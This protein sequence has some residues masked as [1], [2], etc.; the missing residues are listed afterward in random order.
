MQWPLWGWRSKALVKAWWSR[1]IW[2]ETLFLREPVKDEAELEL[3]L[4]LSDLLLEWE[5]QS[6][7]AEE[8]VGR[9]EVVEVERLGS[10]VK[11]I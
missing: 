6:C 5:A 3:E 1:P 10:A 7:W 4:E 11:E 8:S 9:V 2:E